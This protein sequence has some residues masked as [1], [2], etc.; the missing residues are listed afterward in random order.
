ML[1]GLRIWRTTA[2][3]STT[4]EVVFF[5]KLDP[6]YADVAV[7]G[8]EFREFITKGGLEMLREVGKATFVCVT[9]GTFVFRLFTFV[10]KAALKAT[11]DA[12]L[13][14]SSVIHDSTPNEGEKVRKKSISL[15][16]DDFEDGGV[17]AFVGTPHLLNDAQVVLV[18]RQGRVDQEGFHL[19][20]Y[21]PQ[22]IAQVA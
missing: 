14:E 17:L 12:S 9:S 1:S 15:F 4:S 8:G 5:Q 18:M 19:A 21:I 10:D 22:T 3:R 13:K 16:T 6:F 2:I 7:I 20:T 11:P